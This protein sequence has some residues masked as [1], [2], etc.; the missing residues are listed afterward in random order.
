MILHHLWDVV[1]FLYQLHGALSLIMFP[2]V[3]LRNVSIGSYDHYPSLFII[4]CVSFTYTFYIVGSQALIT[5]FSKYGRRSF[6][7]SIRTLFTHAT[8]ACS[9]VCTGPTFLDAAS[10]THCHSCSDRLYKTS[11][12]IIDCS[13][14]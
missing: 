1:C 4:Y 5:S 14:S 10:S 2:L 6:S 13:T 9:V 7:D 3:A 11:S 8:A 12:D